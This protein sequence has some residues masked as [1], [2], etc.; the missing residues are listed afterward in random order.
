MPLLMAVLVLGMG[1][2]ACAPGGPEG[3]TATGSS[4]R[5]SD[6]QILFANLAGQRGAVDAREVARNLA[7]YLPNQSFAIGDAPARPQS[8]GVVLG[9]VVK[10]KGIQGFYVPGDGPTA[11]ASSGTPID[12]DD[13]R[14]QWRVIDATIQVKDAVGLD[15][16][17]VI[18]VGIVISDRDTNSLVR[19]VKSL[20]EVVVVLS[21][22]GFFRFDPDLY[23]LAGFNSLLGTVDRDGEISFRALDDGGKEFVGPLTTW[24]A[25]KSE[26]S[27]PKDVIRTDLLGARL[28]SE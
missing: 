5:L 6:T 23:N 20:G 14:A 10:A 26:V 16:A 18:D 3:G 4:S 15:P 9:T 17:D 24:K 28:V 12:F 7:D 25:I 13:P 19:G 27:I 11:D 2:S 8:A 1:A 22:R 21:R